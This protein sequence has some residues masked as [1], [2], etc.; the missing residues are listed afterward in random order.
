MNGGN[1]EPNHSDVGAGRFAMAELWL[2]T[3]NAF[4]IEGD[5]KD[6]VLSRDQC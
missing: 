4:L 6:A 1:L 2:E 5:K 3:N